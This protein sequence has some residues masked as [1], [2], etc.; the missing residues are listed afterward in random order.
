MSSKTQAAMYIQVDSPSTM[1]GTSI[2][3]KE[4]LAFVRLTSVTNAISVY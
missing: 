4:R 1:L 2:T 3:L